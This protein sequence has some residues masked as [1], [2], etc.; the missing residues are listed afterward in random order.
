M[1]KNFSKGI[2]HPPFLLQGA[3]YILTVHLA[4]LHN[5]SQVLVNEDCCVTPPVNQSSCSSPCNTTLKV[6]VR[7]EGLDPADNSCPFTELI[8]AAQ[9]NGEWRTVLPGA[10]IVSYRTSSTLDNFYHLSQQ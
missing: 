9:S 4:A 6:C 2:P 10:W 8:V 3:D 7:E 1:C 5:P